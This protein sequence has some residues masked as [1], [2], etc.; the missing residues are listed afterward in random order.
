MNK[1]ESKFLS[2]LSDKLAK[3]DSPADYALIAE[4]MATNKQT[5]EDWIRLAEESVL[6]VGTV[7]KALVK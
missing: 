5:P 1:L 6:K 4:L 7:A 3:T 2:L